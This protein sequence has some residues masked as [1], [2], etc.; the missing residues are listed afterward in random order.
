MHVKK[1]SGICGENGKTV[2]PCFYN[3]QPGVSI[4]S[5]YRFF[6]FP[7]RRTTIK[8]SVSS[9]PRNPPLANR[10]I[11]LVS[12]GRAFWNF[13][14]ETFEHATSSPKFLEYF[15]MWDEGL[16]RE[17]GSR[18][19]VRIFQIVRNELVFVVLLNYALTINLDL[20]FWKFMYVYLVCFQRNIMRN[21]ERWMHFK[22]NQNCYLKSN[23]ILVIEDLLNVADIWK[24][25]LRCIIGGCYMNL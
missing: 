9:T 4:T 5:S 15:S 7:S 3:R 11:N 22:V 21:L 20:L 10:V 2:F 13:F 8:L 25:I 18:D 23:K 6:F 24:S 14:C 17:C 19:G 1:E 12:I 16:V